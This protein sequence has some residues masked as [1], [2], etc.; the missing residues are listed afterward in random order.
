MLWTDITIVDG[1]THTGDQARAYMAQRYP[2]LVDGPSNKSITLKVEGKWLFGVKA[3]EHLE[4]LL[5]PKL[6]HNRKTTYGFSM[7]VLKPVRRR[8][9]N[10]IAPPRPK[11][12]VTIEIG[13]IDGLFEPM[14]M[15]SPPADAG[16]RQRLQV[17]GYFYAPLSLPKAGRLDQWA[18]DSWAYFKRVHETAAR[19]ALSDAELRALLKQEIEAHLLAASLPTSGQILAKSTLPRKG[20]AAAIRVPGGFRSTKGAASGL[21]TGDHVYNGGK[22]SAVGAKYEYTV[23]ADRHALESLVYTDNPMLG[24]IPLLVKVTKVVGSDAPVPV[25]GAKVIVQLVDPDLDTQGPLE[26]PPAP[27]KVMDYGR[28]C[29][30]WTSS[31]RPPVPVQPAQLWKPRIPDLGEGLL[32]AEYTAVHKLVTKADA[33]ASTGSINPWIDTWA[34]A[35]PLPDAHADA[36]APEPNWSAVKAWWTGEATRPYP[37]LRPHM[38][39]AAKTVAARILA[40]KPPSEFTGRG[41]RKFIKDMEDALVNA[42]TVPT[43]PQRRNVP[44][45]WCGKAESADGIKAV[46]DVPAADVEG[47]HTKR[48]SQTVDHGTIAHATLPDDARKYPH[49]VQ[50]VTNA[51]GLGGTIFKPSRCGGDRYR[52]KVTLEESWLAAQNASPDSVTTAE[53][54]T[55]IVWRNV[56]I[57]KHVKLDHKTSRDWSA[58]V[59]GLVKHG[60]LNRLTAP[61]FVAMKLDDAMVDAAI[62][63]STPREPPYPATTTA[64]PANAAAPAAEQWRPVA[65]A[66]SSFPDQLRWAYCEVIQDCTRIETIDPAHLDRALD[67]GARSFDQSGRFKKK[68]HWPTM[69]LKDATSP[70]L[71]PLRAHTDYNARKPG[72]AG[73]ANLAMD[74]DEDGEYGLAGWALVEGVIESLADGG[75]MPGL[76]FIQAPWGASWHHKLHDVGQ[77][78]VTS[79]FGAASGA[80]LTCTSGTYYPNFI[81]PAT[82]NGIHELGHVLM[83][84]HQAW[85]SDTGGSDAKMHQPPPAAKLATPAPNDVVC[86]MSYAGCYGELCGR[87][88][89]SLRG[90]AVKSNTFDTG[91]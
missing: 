66:S 59:L 21:F 62:L 86:V 16:V 28:D 29:T 33:Q 50:C 35:A 69:I 83:L 64:K 44:E 31:A 24:R 89:L 85:P 23:G 14:G 4:S 78:L 38:N 74:Y 46:L 87:C 80:L 82:S 9:Q 84:C 77:D 22:D 91:A 41:Q 2:G 52:L 79:G 76:T 25:H 71:I 37:S 73:L 45:K 58:E 34:P 15:G 30:L 10:V 39:A 36:P 75:L 42:A 49:A 63:P 5:G 88:L 70:F 43:D 72:G 53:T 19:K 48:P 55:L 18:T 11:L 61:L 40:S 7:P 13:D 90:W 81:Y 27:D 67:V 8:M 1:G 3:I 56:R 60:N 68:V 6:K 12:Q 65:T 51:K 32:A 20:S 57:Y 54:G 47:F 17:L 26:A